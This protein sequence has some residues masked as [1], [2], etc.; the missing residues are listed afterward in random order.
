MSKREGCRGW[1][2]V[3]EIKMKEK[4][5]VKIIIKIISLKELE[6]YL[7]LSYKRF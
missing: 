2:F 5:L 1:D 4:G 7:F 3:I 6:C